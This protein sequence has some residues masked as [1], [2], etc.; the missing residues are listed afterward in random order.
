MAAIDRSGKAAT[1]R[2]YQT[3]ALGVAETRDPGAAERLFHLTFYKCGSQWIRDVLADERIREYSGVELAAG[4]VD[5]Q[6]EPWPELSAGQLGSPLYSAGAGNW[7]RMARE[8][9]RALVVLRD[10]RDIVVSLVFSTSFS[11]SP[12][13]VTELLRGPI[14]EA[15][16]ASR[17]KLGMYMLA[18]W[19]EYLRTWKDAPLYSNVYCTRYERLL[20]DLPGE[21]KRVFAF[22]GWGVPDAV[23]EA[24]AADNAFAVRSGRR[25]GEEN[26]FSHRRKGIAGDWRNHFDE[27]LGEL[28]EETFPGLLIDLRYETQRDWWRAIP[29]KAGAERSAALQEEMLLAVLAEHQKEL[30]VL[31]QAAAERLAALQAA[32]VAW[33]AQERELSIQRR[34]AGERL[35][36]LQA[37]E[38]AQRA[39]ESSLCWRFGFRP[40]QALLSKLTGGTR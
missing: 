1:L 9:D 4:G 11:H 34:A 16:A 39:V 17:I 2:Q 24:V 40:L 22:L 19:S 21:L 3:T 12:S 28:F 6:A 20:G 35:A 29:G 14:S 5:L 37:A 15:S 25:P 18:Q 13:P 26:V 33:R 10:P 32:D 27:S 7:E 8:G 36:A 38:A 30:S 31:R 23:A